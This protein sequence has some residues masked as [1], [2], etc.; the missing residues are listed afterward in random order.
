MSPLPIDE[1][2]TDEFS[3]GTRRGRKD[4]NSSRNTNR[5]TDE[6]LER[7]RR[8]RKRS[9]TRL[10]PP[11]DGVFADHGRVFSRQFGAFRTPVAGFLSFE[12]PPHRQS[13][14]T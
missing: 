14:S 4:G 9:L 1:I 11:V 12:P 10:S 13:R 5:R 6:G 7:R 3:V 2:I 8:E